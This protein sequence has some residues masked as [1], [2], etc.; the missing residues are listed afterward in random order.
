M[1]PSCCLSPHAALAQL[2]VTISHASGSL[3]AGQPYSLTCSVEV[4]HLVVGYN[5]E[6]TR[7]D[8]RIIAPS[9][10]DSPWLTFDPLTT[11]NGS[12]YTCRATVMVNFMYLRGSNS[13]NLVITGKLSNYFLSQN[14]SY[15]SLISSRL[16]C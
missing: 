9:S 15:Q 6:W 14:I 5:I 1:T 3:T 8:G 12:Q 16:R 13:T 7:Q 4:P 2:P 10:A 11:S